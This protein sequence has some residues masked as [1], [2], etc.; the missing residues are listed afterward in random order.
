MY[1][2]NL[3]FTEKIIAKREKWMFLTISFLTATTHFCPPWSPGRR[4]ASTEIG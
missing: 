2:P 3:S 4:T 1:K